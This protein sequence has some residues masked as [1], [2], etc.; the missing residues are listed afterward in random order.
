MKKVLYIFLFIVLT[1]LLS[2]LVHVALEWPILLAIT[3]NF[4]TYGNSLVWQNWD[5]VHAVGGT[6]LWVLGLMGGIFGGFRYW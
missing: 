3:S 6:V 4:D 5:T 1:S 2:L